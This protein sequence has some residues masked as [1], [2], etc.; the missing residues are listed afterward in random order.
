MI[1]V[2]SLPQPLDDMVSACLTFPL[3]YPFSGIPPASEI[4]IFLRGG[5]FFLFSMKSRMVFFLFFLL[6]LFFSV[7]RLFFPQPVFSI[8]FLVSFFF[9]RQ[10]LLFWW[11]RAG[12]LFPKILSPRFYV[13]SIFILPQVCFFSLPRFRL[14]TS[15]FETV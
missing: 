11:I 10:P 9:F 4:P 12:R 15:R 3:L 2:S 8:N 6:S 13:T 1:A 7:V 5:R 14:T